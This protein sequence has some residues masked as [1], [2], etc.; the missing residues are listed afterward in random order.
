MA[1]GQT[2]TKQAQPKPTKTE[3][4]LKERVRRLEEAQISVAE[5]PNGGPRMSQF[6]EGIHGMGARAR[7]N[8]TIAL[9]V[10]TRKR[11]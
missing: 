3:A 11:A 6:F 4:Q 7:A 2:M 10:R 9:S 5:P 1:D 8:G